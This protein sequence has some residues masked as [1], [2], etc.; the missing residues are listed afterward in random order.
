MAVSM[1]QYNAQNV[2]YTE[3][4]FETV[5]H[6]YGQVA[7]TQMDTGYR[8]GLGLEASTLPLIAAGKSWDTSG[9]KD[10]LKSFAN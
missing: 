9:T 6:H 7:T 5:H 8:A 1:C 3:R 10:T 2:Q 4:I